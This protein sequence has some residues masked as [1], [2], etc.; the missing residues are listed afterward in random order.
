MNPHVAEQFAM[1]IDARPLKTIPSALLR[2]DRPEQRGMLHIHAGS[3]NADEDRNK[4][5][6]VHDHPNSD[7]LVTPPVEHFDQPFVHRSA[8]HGVMRLRMSA[9]G[10]AG[11]AALGKPEEASREE[12]SSW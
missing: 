6:G 11:G 10:H 9:E 12:V 4:L 1:D 5:A 3:E 7:G 2:L 8:C